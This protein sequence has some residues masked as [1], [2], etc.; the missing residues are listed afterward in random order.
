MVVFGSVSGPGCLIALFFTLVALETSP[1]TTAT[2]SSF[3][4]SCRWTAVP[5][6]QPA[7]RAITNET[8]QMVG[9]RLIIVAQGLDGGALVGGSLH[10]LKRPQPGTQSRKGH[11][12]GRPVARVPALCGR[13]VVIGGE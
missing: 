2:G 11:R 1:T 13:P 7:W 9:Y 6:F 4:T 10:L 12:G 5:Q 8:A 3:A